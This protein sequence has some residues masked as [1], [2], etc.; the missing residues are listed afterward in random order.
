MLISISDGQGTGSVYVNVFLSFSSIISNKQIN[1]NSSRTSWAP[2]VRVNVH[3]MDAAYYDIH[4]PIMPV[5]G[6][7]RHA[8]QVHANHIFH[9]V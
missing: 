9:F 3:D 7:H 4:A 6:L 2:E 5:T 1:R 8:P